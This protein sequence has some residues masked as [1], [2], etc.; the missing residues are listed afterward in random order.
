MTFRVEDRVRLLRGERFGYAGRR[1]TGVVDE[2]VDL[3]GLRQYLLDARFDRP[4]VADVQLHRLDA[5][6]PQGGGG[7]AVLVFQ[8]RIDA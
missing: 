8:P 7:L 6:L 5:E 3:A 2:H 4:V 1:D